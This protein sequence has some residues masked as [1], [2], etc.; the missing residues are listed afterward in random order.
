MLRYYNEITACFYNETYT[1]NELEQL[2][3]EARSLYD[4]E[5]IMNQSQEDYLNELKEDIA[6]FA[7]G[8]I[9]IFRSSVTPATDV[10]YFTYDGHECARLYSVYTLRS[11]TENQLSKE[12]FIMRKDDE[13][14]WKILGF[15]LVKDE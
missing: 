10:E 3:M 6:A 13:G 1:D 4:L 14:H 9:T 11:G 7:A 8:N 2:A 12:V 5:L 15:D